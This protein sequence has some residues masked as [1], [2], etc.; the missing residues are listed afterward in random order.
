VLRASAGLDSVY[1]LCFGEGCVVGFLD[2]PASAL[3]C[4]LLSSGV[5]ACFRKLLRSSCKLAECVG[6]VCL[7]VCLRRRWPTLGEAS[8]SSTRF[9]RCSRCSGRPFQQL[10]RDTAEVRF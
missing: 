3:S 1:V 4:F 10:A 7:R 9:S 2:L 8:W 6:E 5:S